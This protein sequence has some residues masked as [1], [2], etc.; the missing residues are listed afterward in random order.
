MKGNAMKYHETR[1]KQTCKFKCAHLNFAFRPYF[2]IFACYL[3]LCILIFLCSL[4][5]NRQKIIYFVT[6]KDLFGFLTWCL[7]GFCS[8]QKLHSFSLFFVCFQMSKFKF[9]NLS[10]NSRFI[11]DEV[12]SKTYPMFVIKIEIQ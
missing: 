5:K 12:K 9:Q 8:R 7:K 1:G 6:Q 3:C 4:I 2:F 11:A 10:E